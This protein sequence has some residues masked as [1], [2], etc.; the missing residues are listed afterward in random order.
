V[1]EVYE[2]KGGKINT[3]M[4]MLC[5]RCVEMCPYAETLKVN[6]G[7]KT[8]FKSRNWLEPPKVE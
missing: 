8:V 7:N 1:T 6:I 3:S 4:C 2:Q 5:L